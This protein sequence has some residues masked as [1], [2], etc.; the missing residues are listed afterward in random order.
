MIDADYVAHF[1]MRVLQDALTEATAA[2]WEKRAQQFEDAAPRPGD[3]TGR[4]TPLEIAAR[5][6]RCLATAAACRA[7]ASL[8]AESKPEP[9]SSDVATV[10]V[11]VAG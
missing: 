5:L 10:L 8:W 6:R 1:Q 4:A 9:I 2:C 11:E 7:H 3:F